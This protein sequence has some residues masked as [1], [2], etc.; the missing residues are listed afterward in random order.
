M[1]D[2]RFKEGTKAGTF[3]VD[4]DAARGGQQIIASEG[5]DHSVKEEI[6]H[7]CSELIV[8]TEKGTCTCVCPLKEDGRFIIAM[9]YK[10]GASSR[11]SRP[12]EIVRGVVADEDL[13]SA[14]C[15]YYLAANQ[16]EKLFF[17]TV[18]DPDDPADW[19]LPNPLLGSD[20][21][22]GS[23]VGSGYGSGHG[24][25]YGY[26]ETGEI[27]SNYLDHM[28]YEKLIGLSRAVQE[29]GKHRYK[30]QLVVPEGMRR[31]TMAVLHNIAARSHVKLYLV[32]SGECTLEDAPDIVIMEE[33]IRYMDKRLFQR[34]TLE[35]LISWGC[36]LGENT[37]KR[38]RTDGLREQ[39]MSALVDL[40]RAYILEADVSAYELES[41]LTDFRERYGRHAYENFL[42]K[43][44]MALY[45]FE[46][47]IMC[48]ER[49]MEIFY[50]CFYKGSPCEEERS[51][52][53]LQIE[54]PY[55][56]GEMLQFIR[57]KAGSKREA[58]S[59]IAAMMD[60]MFQAC[61]TDMDER[62][63]H[64]KSVKFLNQ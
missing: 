63:V 5:L 14:I 3:V 61:V 17:P 59:I 33:K 56:Y 7:R 42:R 60:R 64:K 11:E 23:G 25:G 2:G 6:K 21:G 37:K 57:K 50:L 1:V 24:S 10:V 44:R 49:F 36:S 62:F 27:L 40:T 53:R 13:T 35:T 31:L 12:H 4:R 28:G 52:T 34:V 9:A 38:E 58:K 16:M 41:R 19:E 22:I 47:S 45:E 18:P 30:F 32:E 46:T 48:S 39:K 15:R 51:R 55:D 29:I 26:G 8:R 54:S 43:L 20:T